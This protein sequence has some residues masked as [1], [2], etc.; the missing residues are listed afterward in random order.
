MTGPQLVAGA[1]IGHHENY[2]IRTDEAEHIPMAKKK[3]VPAS[4]KKSAPKTTKARKPAAKSVASSKKAAG[5]KAPAKAKSAKKP[6]AKTVDGIL[7]AFEKERGSKNRSLKST[8]KKI[9]TLT[10]QV[11]SMKAELEKAKQTAVETEIAIDTLD[12]RRDAEVGTLLAGMGVDLGRAAASSK[13][14]DPVDKPT[15]LFDSHAVSVEVQPASNADDN[16]GS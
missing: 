12:S 7:K 6:A 11:A 2:Q 1:G 3:S 13:P 8:R 16:G 10:K 15:P 5:K 9:E 14:K 4:R